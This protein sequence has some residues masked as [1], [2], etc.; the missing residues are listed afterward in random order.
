M[1]YVDLAYRNLKR[2]VKEYV[3]FVITMVLA[4]MLM[5]AFN[6]CAFSPQIQALG[7]NMDSFSTVIVG[8]SVFM[9]LVLTWL[10][11][12]ISQFI[13]RRRSREFGT[14]MLMGMTRAQV[15]RMFLIEQF[16]IGLLAFVIG[17]L[18]GTIL[19]QIMQ[20]ILMNLFSVEYTLHIEGSLTGFLLTFLY[21]IVIYMLELLREWRLLKKLKIRELLY[22]EQQNDSLKKYRF[23]NIFFLVCGLLC[24]LIGISK[25]TAYIDSLTGNKSSTIDLHVSCTL[26]VIS[27]YFLFQGLSSLFTFVMN[28]F[29]G[30]K[31]HASLMVIYG[32]L[33]S[34]M[35]ANRFVLATL[36]VLTILTLCFVNVGMKVK[37]VNDVSNE[38]YAPFDITY[39]AV[40]AHS[41]MLVSDYLQEKGYDYQ[42]VHYQLYA[43]PTLNP[44]FKKLLENTSFYLKDEPVYFMKESDYHK[45]IQL[46]G[47]ELPP[48]LNNQEY[49]LSVTASFEDSIRNAS[50]H[51]V[52]VGLK[53]N[54]V[55]SLEVGQTDS[56]GMI[57]ILN[58]ALLADESVLAYSFSADTKKPTT[59]K[60]WEELTARMDSYVMPSD[61]PYTVQ[62]HGGLRVK[63][64]WIE[65]NLVSF[66][67]I[68]FSLFYAALIFA[69]TAA[70]ILAVQQVSDFD[71]QRMSYRLLGHMGVSKK[72]LEK[73]LAKQI[74]IY[75]LIPAVIPLFYVFP[76]LSAMNH[77]FIA[78]HADTSIFLYLAGSLLLFFLI[79]LCYYSLTYI[80]CKHSLY[81]SDK[82]C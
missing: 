30:M 51:L 42:G 16:C 69:F 18:M 7:R 56:S 29:L 33:N 79:D 38:L 81:E 17:C 19:Y 61:T 26:L 54:Y 60:Q 3:I 74:A 73:L 39:Q 27:V 15:S 31:Y 25:L 20:A 78:M 10:V 72:G 28:R 13:I 76:I 71:R 11:S 40:D 46:K 68:A 63:A 23:Q 36:S 22:A 5:Y 75:F 58:D 52:I 67:I 45:L 1:L 49:G 82:I 21:F 37:E 14:Y 32:T 8:V 62:Y 43:H 12:Y 2:S 70:T 80:T 77:T 55:K 66:A 34:R 59:V 64:K 35:K 65:E 24:F 4:V 6:A 57:V 9:V 48:Q 44:P 50:D 53:R 47:G 41:K